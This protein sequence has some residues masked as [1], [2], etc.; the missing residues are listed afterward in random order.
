[1]AVFRGNLVPDAAVFDL[2]QH[3]RFD[4]IPRRN[5]KSAVSYSEF[6]SNLVRIFKIRVRRRHSTGHTN[7]EAVAAIERAASFNAERAGTFANRTHC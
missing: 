1:M 7:F 5:L 2:S 4:Q 3:P 6:V